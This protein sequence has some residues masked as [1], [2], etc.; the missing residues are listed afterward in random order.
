MP[1]KPASVMFT[2]WGRRGL[3]RFAWEL[4]QAARGDPLL[5]PA[6]SISRQ[7]RSFDRFAE[8]A[9]SL[10]PIDTFTTNANAVLQTWRIPILRRQLFE[11][12]RRD[13][14][15]AVIELLPHVWSPFVMPVVRAAGARYCTIVH[16]AQ[17]HPGDPTGLVKTLLDRS[18]QTA[19]L[20]LTL[21][22]AVA[23]RLEAKGA[24]PLSKIF[25]LFHPDLSYASPCVHAAPSPG[26]PVR[27]LF[28]GR[29]LRYK[30]LPLFLDAIDL[31]RDEGIPIEVGVF[32]E[33]PIEKTAKRLERI[34]AEVVNRWLEDAEIAEML[35]RF[36]AVVLSHTEASQSGVASTALGAGLPVVATPVGGL[37]EQIVDGQTGVIARRADAWALAEAIKRLI[38][39]PDFYR[40]ISETIV[41][42]RQERSME[43]FLEQCVSHALYAG[44]PSHDSDHAAQKRL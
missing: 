44:E 30:G 41:R 14:T 29:I 25:S 17:R 6:V 5:K 11:R 22:G 19:D 42:T 27:L 34:G 39:N 8:F 35:Q 26:E 4:A 18:M 33:G 23:G 38:D 40:G 24:V 1:G 10:F 20:V 13:G 32:G 37:I 7:N 16:D 12:L 2:Y 36:H 21:S 31:L 15:K 43:R 9:D 3:S 28:F